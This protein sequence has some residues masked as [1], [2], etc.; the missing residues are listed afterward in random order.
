MSCHRILLLPILCCSAAL[1]QNTCRIY[2]LDHYDYNNNVGV[3][4]DLESS[5]SGPDACTLG[6][7]SMILAVGNGA[8][9]NYASVTPQWQAGQTYTANV[10]LTAAGPQQ[11]FLN[12]QLAGT[13]TGTFTPMPGA[14]YGSEVP[15]WAA[16]QEDYLVEQTGLEVT[17]GSQAISLPATGTWVQ[18]ATQLLLLGG[19]PIWSAS[20]DDDAN[21]TYTITA[22]F[23]IQA[24]LPNP[25]QYDPYVDQYGQSNYGAWPSKITSDSELQ[26]AIATEQSWLAANPPLNVLDQYGGS[27]VAGWHDQATGFY[28]TAQHNGRW[29]LITP[30]GN[31]CFYISLSAVQPGGQQATPITGRTA[32]F[33]SLPSQT[34]TFAAAYSLNYWGTSVDQNTVFFHFDLA[35]V[36]RKYGSQWQSTSNSLLSQRLGS[37]GFQGMGKWS[38]IIPGIPST[39]VLERGS[40][41]NVV[42]GGHPDV[43]DPSI[44]S[45]LQATLTSQIGDNATNPDIVGWSLGNEIAEDIQPSEVQSILA[46]GA[47]VP[48]KQALVNQALSAIYGGSVSAL[49]T[50]WG[51][52]ASTVAGVYAATNATPPAQDIET[53]REYYESNYYKTIY[54][55]V[56]AIDPH[57]LYLGAWVDPGYWVNPTDWSLIAANTDV[58]G[59]DY[60]AL[61]FA[62]TWDVASLIQTAGKP[63]MV[64]EFSFPPN[65]DGQRGFGSV[66]ESAETES[67]AGEWYVTWLKAAAANPN[68]VGVSWFEYEDEPV[69]GR[70]NQSGSSAGTALVYGEDYAFGMVDVTDQ[71]KYDL[72]MAVRSG[73]LAALD[74]LG[75][76][77]NTARKISSGGH[78]GEG[79]GHFHTRPQPGVLSHTQPTPK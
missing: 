45:Q 7:V 8:N 27:T 2:L 20:L 47:S 26:A 41:P 17:N 64:G 43:F 3:A 68:C 33:A 77:G 6:S 56:K 36:I 74:S 67:E 73:N 48:V 38:S 18:P 35:N 65:Y 49:A 21:Q 70:G 61:Q 79:G 9:F 40:V 13:A 58:I 69:S 78:H 30:L 55:T 75:L 32:E 28:H 66:N 50:A 14:L 46:L 51:I 12:G 44:V 62:S 22:T 53:L 60:Y 42:S 15:S 23:Q 1:G 37:W 72:V 52:T 10:V 19:T 11:L 31:P 71:P 5:N 76:L 16:G 54:Q 34:G 59:F 29:W 63:V 39:P 57:H 25:A 4:L 24:A